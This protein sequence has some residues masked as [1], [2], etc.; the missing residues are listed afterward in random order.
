VK[1]NGA[2]QLDEVTAGTCDAP[3]PASN[4]AAA[5]MLKAKRVKAMVL[6]GVASV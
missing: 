3:Q 1:S 6:I 4:A 2:A 5:H